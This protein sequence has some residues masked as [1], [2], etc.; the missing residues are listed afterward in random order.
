MMLNTAR[1]VRATAI[2]PE[3]C[4]HNVRLGPGSFCPKCPTF[5]NYSFCPQCGV[6]EVTSIEL[7]RLGDSLAILVDFGKGPGV[8]ADGGRILWTG[9]QWVSTQCLGTNTLK[10]LSRYRKEVNP[11]PSIVYG[12]RGGKP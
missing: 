5:N 6:Q 4:A 2:V 11:P 12:G 3:I 8:L 9:E 10:R 7:R 1:I